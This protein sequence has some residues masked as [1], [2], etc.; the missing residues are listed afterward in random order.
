MRIVS[1]KCI[2]CGVDRPIDSWKKNIAQ[3]RIEHPRCKSCAG[4]FHDNKG[5]F[6]PGC[7]SPA[8]GRKGVRYSPGT[9]F[10]KGNVPWNFDVKGIHLSPSTEFKVGEISNENHPGWKGDAVGYDGL[11]RWVKNRRG[12]ANGCEHCGKQDGKFEWANKSH[13]YKRELDDWIS[14]CKKCHYQYDKANW[15]AATRRFNLNRK[16]A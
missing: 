8:K 11:H 6:K 2:D 1:I 5:R 4:L 14:L 10:K 3:Y 15:G 13:E 12:K 16:T 9:E 7:V